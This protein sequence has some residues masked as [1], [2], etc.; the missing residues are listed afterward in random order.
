MLALRQC[1][2]QNPKKTKNE[3]KRKR[4]NAKFKAKKEEQGQM[5]Q[6]V[7]IFALQNTSTEIANAI[8]MRIID[9]STK[10]AKQLI[11]LIGGHGH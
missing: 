3:R 11:K 7:A 2:C 10:R 8:A 5:Q 1:Q 6:C 4:S 9:T